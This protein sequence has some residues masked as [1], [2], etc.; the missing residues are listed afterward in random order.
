MA[1]RRGRNF[2]LHGEVPQIFPHV[3]RPKPA[4]MHRAV[5]ADES[6]DPVH[7]GRLG[8]RT[9]VPET[10]VGTHRL[11]ELRFGLRN[12]ATPLRVI[13]PGARSRNLP[14]PVTDSS[15]TTAPDTISTLAVTIHP[16]G[17]SS[18]KS[19]RRAPPAPL[20]RYAAPLFAP[21]Q[22]TFRDP[23][24]ARPRPATPD[25]RPPTPAALSPPRAPEPPPDAPPSRAY[26]NRT[27]DLTNP[28]IRS[29]SRR[30]SGWRSAS[31]ASM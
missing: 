28:A 13:K 14:P 7:V 11:Q 6:P 9:V 20:K 31:A 8:A 10:H 29:E 25:Q 19:A 30:T 21:S 17:D 22:P 18:S 4:R 26:G 3:P 23:R 12:G 15:L 2:A 1:L 5:I 24:P 27:S 16:T